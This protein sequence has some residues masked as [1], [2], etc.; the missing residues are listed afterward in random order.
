MIGNPEQTTNSGSFS[1]YGRVV[2]P[3]GR[4]AKRLDCTQLYD[5]EVQRL[6]MELKLMQMGLS[7]GIAPVADGSA[8]DDGWGSDNPVAEA[9]AGQPE[10]DVIE[11]PESMKKLKPMKLAKKQ[12]SED[13]W[14]EDGWSTDGLKD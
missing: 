10:E 8:E 1:A 7:R 11:M 4:K 14:A 9:D 2:V 6:A 5:L 12:P 13:D 3:I